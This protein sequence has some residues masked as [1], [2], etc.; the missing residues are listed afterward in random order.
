MRYKQIVLSLSLFGA[1]D[2]YGV[3]FYCAVLGDNK[4][5]WVRVGL[6]LPEAV[7]FLSGCGENEA[8][9]LVPGSVA[10]EWVVPDAVFR[11]KE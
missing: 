6:T 9:G 8:L 1:P 10:W 7:T 2:C 3:G 11:K 5:V 4:F